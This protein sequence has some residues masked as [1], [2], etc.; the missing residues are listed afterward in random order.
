M[1]KPMK[2]LT[3]SLPDNIKSDLER[4]AKLRASSLSQEIRTASINHINEM[5]K[6]L[7]IDSETLKAIKK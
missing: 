7:D 6:K 5:C 4:I 2:Q 3:I 1:K